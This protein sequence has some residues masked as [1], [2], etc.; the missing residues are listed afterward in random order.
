MPA[1]TT[2]N[3]L[4][5]LQLPEAGVLWG[6]GGVAGSLQIPQAEKP[7]VV[8][9]PSSSGR[10]CRVGRNGCARLCGGPQPSPLPRLNSLLSISH[11]MYLASK[12]GLLPGLQFGAQALCWQPN[13]VSGGAGG[14]G[15]AAD[16]ALLQ[17]RPGTGLEPQDMQMGR[18]ESLPGACEQDKCRWWQSNAISVADDLV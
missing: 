11:H 13:P 6:A 8:I 15:F 14:G 3:S 9:A 1:P 12:V 10:H 16:V 5:W 18:S 7:G 4:G 2:N 17:R